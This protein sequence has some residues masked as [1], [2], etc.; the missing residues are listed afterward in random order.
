MSRYPGTQ[1]KVHDNSQATAIVPVSN[2][3]AADAVQYLTSFAS[4]KGPEGITLTSGEDFYTRYGTQDNIDFKKYGQPLLQAS[5]NINNGAALLAKRVVLDDATLG[6]ATL[7]VVLTKYKDAKFEADEEMPSLIKSISFDENSK[8]KYSIAPMVFSIDNTNNYVFA[9]QPVTEYKER[10]QAYKKYIEDIVSNEDTPS[11]IFL[12]KLFGKDESSKIL[13]GFTQSVYYNDKGEVIDINTKGKNDVRKVSSITTGIYSSNQKTYSSSFT[14]E[15]I[16]EGASKTTKP[17]KNTDT[18]EDAKIYKLSISTVD[19]KKV[20]S[21]VVF[22]DGTVTYKLAA[23]KITSITRIVSSESEGKTIIANNPEW[24]SDNYDVSNEE[25]L[26]V[27]PNIKTTGYPDTTRLLND[28][29]VE[30]SGYIDCE[31]VFPMFT[32]FDNGR[33]E[34]IKSISIE[35]DSATS[36]TLKKAIYTLSVYN[37]KTAKRLEKFAFSL[38]PYTRNNNT[39]YSFDIE[40]AVNYVSKQISVKTY[41]ESYDALLETLQ[42]ILDTIDEDIITNND[43]LFGHNLNGKYPAFSSYSVSSFLNRN[44]YIYDYAHLNIFD[45]DILTVNA[46][47]DSDNMTKLDDSYVKYYYYN[48]VRQQQRLIEKLEKGSDGYCLN[49]EIPTSYTGVVVP[50][51]VIDDTD[52]TSD[53]S[54]TIISEITGQANGTVI[55]TTPNADGISNICYSPIL[56]QNFYKTNLKLYPI[57]HYELYTTEEGEEDYRL[58]CSDT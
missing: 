47:C 35:Y 14:P 13:S 32:I 27:A 49:R 16:I 38:N 55:S 25:Y 6:N 22:G 11:N 46:Y 9:K 40:S 1:F 50:F 18:I 17:I 28:I 3:N 42:N 5:M 29:M 41:Y 52:N 15:D 8:S 12:G 45:N 37:Y 48:Y 2:V 20:P 24:S 19:N 7:A 56:E 53:T 54:F 23:Q 39:G 10:Y 21:W 31:Y 51:I 30:N 43:I 58:S 44:T 57:K 33:G 34:S 36:V 26:I 4:I